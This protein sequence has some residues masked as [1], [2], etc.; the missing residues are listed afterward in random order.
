MNSVVTARQYAA[1]HLFYVEGWSYRR[2]GKALGI[3]GPTAYELVCR[4]KNNVLTYCVEQ[5]TPNTSPIVETLVSSQA[6]TQTR[7]MH[8]AAERQD[9]L[10]DTFEAQLER[11]LSEL[12]AL[13]SCMSGD[14]FLPS[15]VKRN[16]YDR[17]EI[18]VLNES[19]ATSLC[20]SA[21]EA[22]RLHRFIP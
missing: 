3:A 20:S 18:T 13:E 10:L 15:H 1:L 21:Y 19:G 12:D 8:A 2:I 11:R 5:A 6:S 17:W 7:D 16:T 22:R 9:E 4:G 14:S